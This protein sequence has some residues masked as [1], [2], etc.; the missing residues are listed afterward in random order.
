MLVTCSSNGSMSNPSPT[1]P[2]HRGAARQMFGSGSLRPP[3]HKPIVYA[4]GQRQHGIRTTIR[5]QQYL[6][7]FPSFPLLPLGIPIDEYHRMGFPIYQNPDIVEMPPRSDRPLNRGGMYGG[8]PEYYRGRPSYGLSSGRFPSDFGFMIGKG[9]P[10]DY[11]LSSYLG[12]YPIHRVSDYDE[13]TDNYNLKQP[14]DEKGMRGVSDQHVCDKICPSGEMLCHNYC[15][16]INEELRCDSKNDCGDNEDEQECGQVEHRGAKCDETKNYILCPKTN[17]CISK[18]WLCDGDDDCGDYSDE[19]HCGFTMN[20][21][22]D[23][24]Q[25]ENGLCIP[26]LWACDNDNDCKDFSDEINCTKIGCAENEF[27]CSDSTCI[28]MSWKCDRHIDCTDGTDESDCDIEPPYCNEAEFQ[29]TTHKC[30]KKEFKCDGDDDCDDWSDEDDC[31]KIPGTCSIGEFRCNSGKCIPDRYRCDRQQDCDESEDESGCDYNVTM[32]CSS[33]EYTCEN[34]ACILKTW[35]CDGFQDCYNGEDE[36]KCQMVCDESKFPCSRMGANNSE[37]EFCINRKHMCDGQKDC[38]TGEDEKDCPT[39]RECEHNTKCK[40]LCVSSADGKNDCS[41]FT[42]YQLASDRYSCEDIDECM[43]ATD[44][45]CSQTCNNTIGSFKCGCMTGYVLRPDLRTCK[46]MGA[47]PTLLFANRM[48]IRQVSLSNS[49]YTALLKG[50]TDIIKS[51][52]ES[53][54]GVAID[55]IHDLIFWTDSG[56]RRIEVASLDGQQRA[57]IAA[58][59]VDKPRAIA[60][61]PGKALVFWTD[62]GP[63]PKIERSEMDGSNRKSI[64][65]ESVFWPN[66]LTLDYTSNQLYWADAKHNVIETSMFDGSNRRKV[67]SKGLP[68]PFALTIFED[69]IFWTD[70]HT[71]SISTANKAT[72]AGLR[73]I[74]SQLHFPMDIHSYHP[75][76]QPRYQNH[77]GNNNGGC[78]HLCLPNENS[79]TCT[80]RMGQK[81]KSDKKNCQKPDKFLLFARKKDLRM[82]YLDGNAQHQYEMV[83]PVNGIKSAVAIAWDSRSDLIYWTDVERNSLNRAFW[84]GTY[85][86]VLISSNIISPAGISLDWAT[87]KIYWTDAGTDRIEVVNANGTKRALLIWEELDKPRDIVV[88]PLGGS[89]YWS[90]WGEQPKIERADMDGTN[91]FVVAS[92]NLTWPNGLAVDH[93]AGKIY[94]TDAGSRSIEFANLDGSNRK[95]L[96]GNIGNDPPVATNIQTEQTPESPQPGQK[97]GPTESVDD[98]D[99]PEPHFSKPPNDETPL[100]PPPAKAAAQEISKHA[101]KKPKKN[102]SDIPKISE[103]SEKTIRDLYSN[104]PSKF[105]IPVNNLLAFLENSFGCSNPWKE[106]QHFTEN[107]ESLLSDM[108]IIYPHLT[109]RSLKNRFSRITKKLKKEV[110]PDMDERSSLGSQSDILQEEYQSDSSQ[111]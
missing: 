110:E 34:S 25:C 80:C 33:D 91:R 63:S 69:A 101:R 51:G 100:M 97:R 108:H 50:T 14:D 96:L 1:H 44:P 29:C 103:A 10:S 82:K 68:H 43:Y 37:T 49:K 41:C 59:D 70:W 53:P 9:L 89:M 26:K 17:R 8:R 93:P 72:G 81:L 6:P 83:I 15:I 58:S 52:L 7:A 85:Q 27:E 36:I 104:D 56:T 47:P 13:M 77:C 76:R 21:T 31:P 106:A 109:D 24:F 95:I 55:W 16:C 18:D 66:G 79:Y 64:I 45:V 35:V 78:A 107:I 61:H 62:W 32:T 57:I 42:G 54:G 65:I 30:I 88:D 4:T 90:E 5:P 84:N 102:S 99:S 94:W 20:C 74:H 105:S 46:A 19:T 75:Q 38:P 111:S 92:R 87:D 71:K 60:V 48:D 12:R 2:T 23:Q 98:S 67:I 73:T 11:D 39:E 28:S 22:N 40:Q 86:E 3:G